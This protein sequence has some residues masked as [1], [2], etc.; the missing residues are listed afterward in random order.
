L[1][2]QDKA[3]AC[4][5]L[6]VTDGKAEAD[7]AAAL[8]KWFVATCVKG[9]TIQRLRD[10]RAPEAWASYAQLIANADVDVITAVRKVDPNNAIV[11]TQ[12]IAGMIEHLHQLATGAVEPVGKPK[13]AATARKPAAKKTSKGG[14]LENSRY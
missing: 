6:G 5:R 12:S 8:T 1:N 4:A 7:L 3:K 10:F 13:K 9:L 14:V 2:L 11:L